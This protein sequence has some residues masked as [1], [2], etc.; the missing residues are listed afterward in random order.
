MAMDQS[1]YFKHLG[2]QNWQR[3]D[4]TPPPIQSAT[5]QLAILSQKVARCTACELH[6][7]RTQTVFGSGNPAA[8]LMVIGEAPGFYEDQQG[9]PFVG[10]AG[11]L[12]TNMLKAIQLA[13]DDVYIANVLKSRP[14]NNRDPLPPEIEACTPFLLEQI[15]IIQPKLLLALGR[16]A[17][18]FLLKTQSSLESLR[19]K[20]HRDARTNTPVIVT[21][22]PAYL[23]RN[24][25]DKRKAWADLLMA[26]DYLDKSD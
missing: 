13:R 4:E 23:L 20:L 18:H 11:Q 12:L 24:P 7:T 8:T 9:L 6:K 17:A 2:L 10:K 26:K 19:S 5:E 16:F 22:H 14:P 15:R 3:R 25:A 21:Y 1:P